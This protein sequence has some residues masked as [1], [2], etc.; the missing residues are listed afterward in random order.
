M[1]WF[2]DHEGLWYMN[3]LCLLGFHKKSSVRVSICLGTVLTEQYCYRC[4]K[5]FNKVNGV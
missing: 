2:N 1:A 3:I 4:G 5:K